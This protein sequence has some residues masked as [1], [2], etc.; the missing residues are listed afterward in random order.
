MGCCF[1][2]ELLSYNHVHRLPPKFCELRGGFSSV[3][4]IDSLVC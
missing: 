3:F 2:N 4:R 1:A